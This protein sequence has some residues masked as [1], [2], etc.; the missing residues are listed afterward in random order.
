MSTFHRGVRGL[1]K[2]YRWVRSWGGIQLSVY[3]LHH[4]RPPSRGVARVF[5]ETA[6][7]LVVEQEV[8]AHGG[9]SKV[10]IGYERTPTSRTR[11]GPQP[12]PSVLCE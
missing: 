11:L 9:Q 6:F 1:C 3:P 4:V 2:K 10:A 5:V 12:I 7:S 8:L